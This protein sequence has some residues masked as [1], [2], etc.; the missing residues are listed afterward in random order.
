MSRVW[1]IVLWIALSLVILGAVLF[2]AALLTGASFQ[3]IGEL[4]FGGQAELEAWL[5]AGLDHARALWTGVL[6][7]IR[8]LF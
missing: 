1:R 4:V 2:G 3:R 6:E 7:Q 8:S 5:Q